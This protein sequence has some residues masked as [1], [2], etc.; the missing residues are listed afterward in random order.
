MNKMLEKER[1]KTTQ[2]LFFEQSNL[3]IIKD[4]VLTTKEIL[5]NTIDLIVTSPPYRIGIKYA[6]RDDKFSH[7]EYLE[8][9]KKWMS[10]CFKWLKDD[11]RFCLN[12]PLEKNNGGQQSMG[13][14]LTCL[15]K[16]IGF[17]YYSTI[18]WNETDVSRRTAWESWLNPSAPHV[19]PSL[20][21]IIVLY[22]NSWKKTSRSG[23]PDITREEFMKWTKGL[24]N[25]SGE[26][27]KRIGHPLPFPLEL[28]RRCIK[29]FSSVGDT[30][31][32]PFLGSGTTLIAAHLNNRKGIGIE[33]DK[34]YCELAKQRL[35]NEAEGVIEKQEKNQTNVRKMGLSTSRNNFSKTTIL[36]RM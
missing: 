33:I 2:K 30:V 22:K 31:L 3:K 35:I 25:F 17:K 34:K 29:L 36:K 6:F 15:A 7:E 24:W 16:E 10:R 5:P 32:D 18:I 12:V 8:F 9:S 21:L 27:K 14:D 26:R 13:A 19:I 23:K 28:P 4:D 20:D 1:K 11:R